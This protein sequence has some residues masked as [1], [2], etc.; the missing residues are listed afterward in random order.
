MREVVINF[1]QNLSSNIQKWNVYRLLRFFPLPTKKYSSPFYQ[2]EGKVLHIAAHVHL[3][4][5]WEAAAHLAVWMK[6]WS[7]EG[8]DEK[9]IM[10]RPNLPA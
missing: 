8:H 1:F 7:K 2:V 6:I 3:K 10:S 5:D 9:R 4:K